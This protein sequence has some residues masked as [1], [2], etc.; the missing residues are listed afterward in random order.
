MP[1][2]G[3]RRRHRTQGAAGPLPVPPSIPTAAAPR[4]L[5]PAAAAAAPPA[6][7]RRVKTNGVA[8][9]PPRA[10]ARACCPPGPSAPPPPV[11]EE[12]NGHSPR[13][14]EPL[15]PMAAAGP[16]GR[17]R[18]KAGGGPAIAAQRPPARL[19]VCRPAPQ[20][21]SRCDTSGARRRPLHVTR[22]GG[23]PS[24]RDDGAERL[25][26]VA[27]RGEKREAAGSSP[28]PTTRRRHR[29]G[30]ASPL[31]PELY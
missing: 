21:P 25:L 23:A 30:H 31:L 15:A 17:G 27:P 13:D 28:G 5:H 10:R 3:A 11:A 29:H 12:A 18:G 14:L 8:A 1:R 20:T 19:P 9:R 26:L 16:G 24:S 22:R 7:P 6:H 4:R 2:S